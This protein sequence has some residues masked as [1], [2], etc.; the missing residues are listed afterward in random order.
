MTKPGLRLRGSSVGA[1]GK[2][3]AYTMG[4]VDKNFHHQDPHR[5][6]ILDAP[7][8]WFTFSDTKQKCFRSRGFFSINT[9][10]LLLSIKEERELFLALCVAHSS[11]YSKIIHG[12]YLW[13]VAKINHENHHS[14]NLEEV[15]KSIILLQFT[16]T[17][18]KLVIYI[19][20][21]KT[22]SIPLVL[23]NTLES[24]QNAFL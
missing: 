4:Q 19:K 3:Q 6:F 8:W 18:T 1:D 20:G 21:I 2:G 17:D 9:T 13:N 14:T 5:H 10:L 12:Y 22:S 23:A 7:V 11:L 24:V 16:Y 15:C